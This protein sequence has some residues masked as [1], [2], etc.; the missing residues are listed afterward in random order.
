MRTGH[1][2]LKAK[3]AKLGRWLTAS[4]HPRRQTP[5][6][7]Q[8]NTAFW[9]ETA[10]V[11]KSRDNNAVCKSVNSITLI[12]CRLAVNVH[13]LVSQQSVV[14]YA[15]RL[16]GVLRCVRLRIHADFESFTSNISKF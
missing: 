16:G 11:V 7:E 12:S 14:Q 5:T 6:V 9:A 2:L 13:C 1:V 10:D 4:T 3:T 15:R 8:L